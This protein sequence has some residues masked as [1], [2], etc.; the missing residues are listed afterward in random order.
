MTS[1]DLTERQIAV[2]LLCYVACLALMLL[3]MVVIA[4]QG[5]GFEAISL[6]ISIY[7]QE[8]CFK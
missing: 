4:K 1:T 3:C 5:A 8:R 7:L 6:I 2:R